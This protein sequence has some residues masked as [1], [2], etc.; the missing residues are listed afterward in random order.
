MD[1]HADAADVPLPAAELLMQRGRA[2][3]LL[4]HQ[5]HQRQVAAI[6]NVL[7]PFADD[8]GVLH[9]MLDEHALRFGNAL[10]K[11]VK[12][13]FVVGL[14]RPQHG[15]LAVLEVTGSWDIFAVRVQC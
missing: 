4:V 10:K 11:Q 7:A 8:L 14:Q 15:L 13:L 2:D 5:A 1:E 12:V 6:I 9:A 3:D